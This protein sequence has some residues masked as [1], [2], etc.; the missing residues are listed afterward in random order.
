MYMT[1]REPDRVGGEG[2]GGNSSNSFWEVRELEVNYRCEGT[3]AW[4][5]IDIK[6]RHRCD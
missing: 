2:E 4:S 1:H 3:A 5:L 6:G